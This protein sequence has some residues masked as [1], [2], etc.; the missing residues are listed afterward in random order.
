MAFISA[1]TIIL[2]RSCFLWSLG[3]LLVM[4]PKI[5]T[6]HPFVIL[7]GQAMKLPEVSIRKDNPLVG[8]LAIVLVTGGLSDIPLLTIPGTSY[9]TVNSVVGK[10]NPVE[11]SNN[12][13]LTYF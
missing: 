9:L 11:C 1:K 5:V 10:L 3:Y 12:Y 8:L 7:L 6:D 13:V 4:N 2:F